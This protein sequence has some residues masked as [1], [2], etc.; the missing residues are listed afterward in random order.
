MDDDSASGVLQFDVRLGLW[1]SRRLYRS[2]DAV[3]V[4]TQYVE[5]SASHRVCL[6]TQS[7]LEKLHSLVQVAHQ[8]QG[9]LSLGLF[10]AG[11]E[12]FEAAQRYLDFLQ[13]CYAAVR[14]RVTVSVLVPGS[15]APRQQPRYY[16]LPDF[17]DCERPEAALRQF[18]RPISAEQ[19]S[20]RVRNAY[21][22]NHMRN[23]ARKNCQAEW[24]FLTDVDVVPSSNLSQLLEDFLRDE[25]NRCDKCAYVIPTFELDAR[26]RF[27]QNKSE[28]V[29]L[30]K[31]S[32]A[33]PFHHKVFIHNQFATNFTRWMMDSQPGQA[34]PP[35]AERG[36]T[37]ARVSHDVTNFEFLYEPFYVARDVAPAHDERFMGYGYTRN[38]QVY[39]MYVAGY[40]FK[41]LTPTFTVHWG[42]QTRKSRPAWR[43]RQNS[44][45]RKHF[46]IF[47]K[48]VF[49]R[50]SRDPLK[51][52][53]R[54][55]SCALRSALFLY[56]I[57][58]ASGRGGPCILVQYTRKRDRSS[59]S[60]AT[61]FTHVH[62]CYNR[63]VYSLLEAGCGE[64]LLKSSP[65]AL[66]QLRPD[67]SR[68]RRP[69]VCYIRKRGQS[70]VRASE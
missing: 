68:A 56:L 10:V 58:G 39:E 50:Y 48:E 67:P 65:T 59:S 61:C 2:W 18:A 44:V 21:P 52:R 35:P 17:L 32:L 22:Q 11:D 4:G 70:V 30:A 20:W 49:A 69:Y 51:M 45:N 3:L 47:K 29:R 9:P 43:E 53:S 54:A 7:S 36:D 40:K 66:E 57:S 13:R 16:P 62:F 64:L 6:A 31:K 46:E 38:T 1:D 37:R 34:P 27:P 19:A 33:R 12:E 15:R 28:L 42:L 55:R 63:D 24:V 41:V 23:L 25:R 14:E 60:A 8:W 5:L 26:V